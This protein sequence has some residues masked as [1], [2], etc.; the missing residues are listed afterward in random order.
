MLNKLV[1]GG[2]ELAMAGDMNAE[3]EFVHFAQGCLRIHALL[4]YPK[5]GAKKQ[6]SLLSKPAMDQH[7]ALF[8][9]RSQLKEMQNL[10]RAGRVAMVAGQ[11]D[12]LHALLAAGFRF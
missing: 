6:R 5:Q 12:E 11:G 8:G 7:R 9:I 10:L 1:I 2:D 4:Q 3:P